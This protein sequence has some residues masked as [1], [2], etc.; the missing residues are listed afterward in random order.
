MTVQAIFMGVLVVL[1]VALVWSLAR[2]V[3]AERRAQKIMNEATAK[4]IEALEL[5]QNEMLEH[6]KAWRDGM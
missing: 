2:A 1:L 3:L 4:M 6:T 5:S